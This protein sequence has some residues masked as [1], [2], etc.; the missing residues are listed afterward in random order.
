MDVPDGLVRLER[1]E[2]SVDVLTEAV[3]EARARLAVLENLVENDPAAGLRGSF[4]C[5][6][7][8]GDNVGVR[9]VCLRCSRQDSFGWAP[10][11]EPST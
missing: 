4:R 10:T 11:D 9:V 6:C 3:E 1:L 2:G 8:E 5:E 7:G